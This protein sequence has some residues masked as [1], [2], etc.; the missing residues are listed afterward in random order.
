MARQH[1]VQSCDVND[2]HPLAVRREGED[3][4]MTCHYGLVMDSLLHCARL[5]CTTDGQV[6]EVQQRVPG[7]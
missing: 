5:D 7:F 4:V 6:V 3:W 2:H 1:N